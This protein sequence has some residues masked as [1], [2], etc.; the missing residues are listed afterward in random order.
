MDYA[1]ESRLA[2]T[3]RCFLITTATLTAFPLPLTER[4]TNNRADSFFSDGSGFADQR[5][6]YEIEY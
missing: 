2:L 6:L 3:R 4:R 1:T 5:P